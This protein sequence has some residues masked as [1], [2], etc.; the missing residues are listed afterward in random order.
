MFS[1][2]SKNEGTN[3]H[4]RLLFLVRIH[5]LGAPFRNMLV[6]IILIIVIIMNMLVIIPVLIA[7]FSIPL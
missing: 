5:L 2:L 6:I 4:P 3:N 7:I 1:S